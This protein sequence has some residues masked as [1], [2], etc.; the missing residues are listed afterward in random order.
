[1]GAIGPRGTNVLRRCNR[2]YRDNT[3][4]PDLLANVDPTFEWV[5]LAA[6]IEGE[7]CDIAVHRRPHHRAI[8]VEMRR[9]AVC[10]RLLIG[11]GR[12]V[13]RVL[14][15]LATLFRDRD[16]RQLGPPFGLVPCRTPIWIWL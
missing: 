13:R 4:G 7:V 16:L 2:K 1:M 8:E 11:C 14:R 5:R 15:I 6:D 12:G 9:A 3:A 10:E